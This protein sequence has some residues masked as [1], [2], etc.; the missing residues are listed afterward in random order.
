MLGFSKFGGLG[1]GQG[2]TRGFFE[3]FRS[4]VL[5]VVRLYMA[6]TGLFSS[7]WCTSLFTLIYDAVLCS[8]EGLR[9]RV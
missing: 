3:G 4:L 2:F 6:C 7:C 9:F 1:F 5:G 8:L